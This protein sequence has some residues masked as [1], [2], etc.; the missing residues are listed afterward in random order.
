MPLGLWGSRA[1]AVALAAAVVAV[2]VQTVRLNSAEVRGT[3]AALAAANSFL[4]PSVST[5]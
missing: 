3:R 5:A 2:L 4:L 1:A